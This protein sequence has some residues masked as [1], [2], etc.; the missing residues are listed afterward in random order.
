MRLVMREALVSDAERICDL[1]IQL[2]YQASI[3][4]IEQRVDRLSKDKDNV[5]FVAILENF[6]VGWVHVFATIR[7]ESGE[8]GEIGGLVVDEHYRGSGIGKL[9]VQKSLEWTKEM[10]LPSLRIRTNTTRIETHR[11]YENCGFNELKSQKVFGL[12]L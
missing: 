9:L 2:G 12:K 11:F 7:V 5:I 10:N 6:S 1:S 4:S 8:F 3:S